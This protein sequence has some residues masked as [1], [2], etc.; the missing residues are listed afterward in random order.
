VPAKALPDAL[1]DILG[2][3]RARRPLIHHL[4]NWVVMNDT[5]NITLHAG[6]LPV[7]AQAREEVGEIAASAQALVVNLGTLT[8]ERLEA[9][10]VAAAVANQRG[11]PI[12]LDPV[13]AGAS[14]W[15]TASALHLLKERRVAIIRCNRAEA[16]ALLDQVGTIRGVEDVGRDSTEERLTLAQH[17]ADR[18][19]TT[20]AITGP[21]DVVSDGKRLLAVD[22]GDPLLTTI[23]G[24]GCM[25]TTLVACCAAVESNG[26]LAAATALAAFGLAAE[27]AAQAAR[28]PASF[29]VALFDHVYNLGPADLAAGARVGWLHRRES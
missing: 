4:T 27:R 20:V 2:R 9:I 21:R 8:A 1:A 23:T 24:S 7:M 16:A 11:I 14:A 10:L 15:R 22:N 5:A 26:V 12:V 19:Q 25:A 17:L 29:K 6:A 3:V 13:G 28:G 18:F